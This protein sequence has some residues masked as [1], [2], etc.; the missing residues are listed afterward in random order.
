MKMKIL[1][2]LFGLTAVVGLGQDR[3]VKGK[4][5]DG[6]LPLENVNISV[7]DKNVA[8][9]T[10]TDGSYEIAVETG[11]RLQ[12]TYTGMRTITIRVEDVTR[13]LNPVM[14]PDVEKL[15]EVV[16]EGSRRRSQKDLQEDYV[17][18][19]N[20]IK[21]AW[22]FLDADRA[23]GNVRTLDESEVNPVNIGILG[24]LQN[25]FPGVRVVGSIIGPRNT[26]VPGQV[27]APLGGGGV[28][29]R[30]IGSIN[31]RQAAIFDV[32]GQIFTD[33]P[34]WIDIGNIKRIAVLNNFA[35]TTMYGSI[36]SGG[37]IVIN[38]FSGSGGGN[39]TVDR[40]R[41]RNN[42]ATGKVLSQEEI[43]E[44]AP[45]Y[46][47]ELEASTS[48]ETA[49]TIFQKYENNFS[50]SPYFYLNTYRYFADNWNELG[51]ADAI[52]AENVKQ[53]ENNAVL[54]K[55]LAYIYEAQGRVEKAN[56]MYKEAFIQ[57]PNYA[58][59]Y[60]DMAN[61]YR[62]L[63]QPR[64]AASIHARY[65]YLIDEGF[66]E[67]DS[68]GFGPVMTREF[69]NLLLLNRNAVVDGRK[70]KKLYVAKEDFK[71]TRLVFEWNDG[72]AEF[73]LQ[74]VNPENQYYKWKHSL[75]DN[76]EEI[77]REKDFGYNVKEYLIDGSLPGNWKINAN[78]L[79]N[80][81]LSPT[82]LKATVYYN[83]GTRS[84]RKETRVFKLSL[85]NVNQQLFS[86][87]A[88]GNGATQ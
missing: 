44:N 72:E 40:A 66:L 64:Q 43:L 57:R 9:A 11:D 56:N 51:Y 27:G 29:I 32:D 30:G 60:M 38:T 20:I 13:F 15:D 74:F 10:A 77:E 55:A 14:I 42:Y 58:Q 52:I 62:D 39:E 1:V 75:A 22:G 2:V 80:K 19:K 76:P 85:K 28:F 16:V 79:G 31:N 87:Q 84:Q 12:Y 68:T 61:S 70:S 88:S 59:S 78:Y 23:P 46:I 25:R 45:S 21:T 65:E 54:L 26:S 24:L 8:T 36:G 82:F 3:T 67:A 6:K 5:S 4:V 69:N 63:N 86:V 50:N 37:V 33:V 17:I 47:Q 34:F 53:F 35:T 73:E 18:N 83:Y 41:L 49:K 81:S 7:I 48:F 71:G